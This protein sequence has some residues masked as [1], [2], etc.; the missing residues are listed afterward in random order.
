MQIVIFNAMDAALRAAVHIATPIF[1]FNSSNGF[2]VSQ[3]FA[4]D[5]SC[6]H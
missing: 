5:P 1:K 6:E 3:L 4:R 2:D